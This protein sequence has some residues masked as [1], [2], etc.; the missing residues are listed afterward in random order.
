MST[1]HQCDLP[2]DHRRRSA[3]W[4]EDQ[5]VVA[6]VDTHLLPVLALALQQPAGQLGLDLALQRIERGNRGW[7]KRAFAQSGE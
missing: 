4:F 1:K 6:V 3:H 7:G 2:K 5:L